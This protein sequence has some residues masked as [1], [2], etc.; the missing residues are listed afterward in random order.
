MTHAANQAFPNL[1][2]G[3]AFDFTNRFQLVRTPLN[4]ERLSEKRG[5][6]TL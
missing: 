5:Y 3:E 6:S 1:V 2:P 4:A